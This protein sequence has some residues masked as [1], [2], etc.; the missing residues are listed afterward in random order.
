MSFIKRLK[1]FSSTLLILQGL[2]LISNVALALKDDADQP[3]EILSE[4][5]IADEVKGINTFLGNVEVTQGSMIMHS[6]KLITYIENGK[7][8]GK[9][10]KLVAIG[11]PDA[12]VKIKQAMESGEK[13]IDGES[14]RAEYYPEKALLRL[15]GKAVVHQGKNTYISEVIE[16]DSRNAIVKASKQTAG[17]QR[18]RVILQP[19]NKK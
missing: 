8:G 14:L 4:T 7:K 5:A 1:I 15:I 18:V 16:Y 2:G 13:S 10:E 11:S 12:L 19:K 9:R 6:D 3:I 17:N